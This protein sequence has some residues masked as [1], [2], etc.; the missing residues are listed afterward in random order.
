MTITYGLLDRVLKELGLIRHERGHQ[1]IYSDAENNPYIFYPQRPVNEAVHPWH[2]SMARR[3]VIELG[4]ISGN[5]EF[6]RTLER[7]AA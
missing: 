5:E 2:L 7:A 4:L 3:H 6:E 1:V